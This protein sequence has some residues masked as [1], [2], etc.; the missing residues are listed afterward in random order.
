MSKLLILTIFAIFS[1]AEQSFITPREY[2]EMLYQNPRGIGCHK[3]HGLKGERNVIV[4]YSHKKKDKEIVAPSINSMKFDE[5]SKVFKENQKRDI[6]PRYFLTN[7]EIRT[8]FV[9]L[10]RVNAQN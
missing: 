8:L 6:M 5:F 10:Q 9:Y 7:Q 4:K 3:C 1:L 2:G